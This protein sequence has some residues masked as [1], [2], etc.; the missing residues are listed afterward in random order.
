MYAYHITHKHFLVYMVCNFQKISSRKR[1]LC[2]TSQHFSRYK[3][4]TSVS[5]NVAANSSGGMMPCQYNQSLAVA[6]E[7]PN[8][9]ARKGTWWKFLRF[10]FQPFYI[11]LLS[12]LHLVSVH[13]LVQFSPPQLVKRQL[14]PLCGSMYSWE[15]CCVELERLPSCL[16]VCPT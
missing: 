3:Y 11:Y 4:E 2:N 9:N 1:E 6:D 5:H 16:W 12:I 14:A 13:I 7:M 10:R 15:T 8:L